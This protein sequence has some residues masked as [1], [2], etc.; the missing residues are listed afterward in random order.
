MEYIKARR[1]SAA[2]SMVMDTSAHAF[3]AAAM[4]SA[5]SSAETPLYGKGPAVH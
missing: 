2:T 5:A 3:D 4:A 1:P